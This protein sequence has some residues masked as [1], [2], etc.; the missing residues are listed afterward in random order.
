[1]SNDFDRGMMK[2]APFQSLVE[3]AS[4]LAK[5]R[6]AKNQISKPV[7]ASEKAEEINELLTHYQ[8][9]EVQLTYWEKGYLYQLKG[10]IK[11]IDGVFHYLIMEDHHVDF[12]QLVDLTLA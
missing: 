3:Q 7:L 12:S 6:R 4:S 9:E 8:Q 5:M 2:W 10:T 1:M 11:K